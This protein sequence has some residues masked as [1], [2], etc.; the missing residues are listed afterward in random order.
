VFTRADGAEGLEWLRTSANRACLVL[1]DL[2]MP[3]MD[4]GAFLTEV[5]A[6]P[7]LR[8]LRVCVLS[9]DPTPAPSGADFMLQ[10]PV[11]AAA[12]LRVVERLCTRAQRNAAFDREK[13][14]A[15]GRQLLATP[16]PASR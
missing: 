9:A 14:P 4:G 2:R 3:V 12:L 7:A 16:A 13:T 15:Q 1:L 5:R 8:D 10:K 11:T 6:T